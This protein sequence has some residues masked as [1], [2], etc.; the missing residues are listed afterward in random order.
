MK[1]LLFTSAELTFA[2][3]IH[4]SLIKAISYCLLYQTNQNCTEN[5][6]TKKKLPNWVTKAT[7]PSTQIPNSNEGLD[8]F[9]LIFTGGSPQP[10]N[11]GN[12]EGDGFWKPTFSSHKSVMCALDVTPE[13]QIC[14]FI[15]HKPHMLPISGWSD[16][17]RSWISFNCLL[18]PSQQSSCSRK[19]LRNINYGCPG[20]AFDCHWNQTNEEG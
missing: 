16:P 18:S 17:K 10:P 19:T 12:Q 1:N 20:F 6:S 3:C 2:S 11:N 4:L 15:S 13:L 14:Q 9:S 7:L 5:A 8:S